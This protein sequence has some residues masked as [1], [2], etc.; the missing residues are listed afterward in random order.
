MVF[1][2]K[3]RKNQEKSATPDL[4]FFFNKLQTYCLQPDY[5]RCLAMELM[6]L[7]KK[8]EKI[9]IANNL[10]TRQETLILV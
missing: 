1:I 10:K 2:K 4:R 6:T 8:L 9:I 5:I 7:E 3:N